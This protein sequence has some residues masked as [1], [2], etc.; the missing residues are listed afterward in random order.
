MGSH[1]SVIKK[2]LLKYTESIKRLLEKLML[3]QLIMK[4]SVLYRL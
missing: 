1:T 3:C 4:F 2:T